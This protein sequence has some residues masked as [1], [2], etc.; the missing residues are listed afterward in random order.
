MRARQYTSLQTTAITPV[1]S[2][3]LDCPPTSAVLFLPG[4]VY[5][6]TELDTTRGDIFLDVKNV[7]S[8]GG[9]Y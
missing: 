3:P 4:E 2:H 9:Y 7:V 1:L 6:P 5:D 8:G